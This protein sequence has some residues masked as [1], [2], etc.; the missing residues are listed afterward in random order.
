MDKNIEVI[1]LVT[2]RAKALVKLAKPEYLS[3]FSIPDLFHFMQ[4]FGK[5]V[6][7]RLGSQVVQAQKKLSK[8]N[9]ESVNYHELKEDLLIKT[10]HLN[11]YQGHREAI[12]KAIHPLDEFDQLACC[13]KVELNLRHLFN[14][15]KSLAQKANI[16]ITLGQASKILNQ[17]PSI[18]DGIQHW[19]NYLKAEIDKLD[20][21]M[22][23]K[24]WLLECVIPYAYWQFHFKKL[25]TKKKDKALKK[26]Y[27]ERLEFA[28]IRYQ[29]L[30]SDLDIEATQ[31]EKLINW[32]SKIVKTF[33]RASSKVEGRNGYLAFMHH[34]NKGIPE[35]RKKVLTI[36]HNFDI[37]NVDKN[38]PAERLFDRQFPNLFEFILNDF[39][40]LPDP[41]T[42][43]MKT[44]SS[45]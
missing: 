11:Q 26:Y 14:D 15:I 39:G 18:T 34:A 43:T 17:I 4:D 30:F 23:H 38:T 22:N 3:T 24:K 19:Q 1:A 21:E 45:L 9:C 2:D 42:R 5:M 20:L 25:T 27:G 29:T 8:T 7:A 12:N 28:K 40:K 41:R 33:H 44:Y 13:E 35:Q 16:N 36:V 37:R 10:E 32:A 6:G 31:K